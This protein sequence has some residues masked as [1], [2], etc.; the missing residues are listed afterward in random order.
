MS[1]PA[2]D[3]AS[4]LTLTPIDDPTT[5]DFNADP[6]RRD[7]PNLG[8]PRAKRYLNKYSILAVV[9]S[10]SCLA[11]TCFT[12]LPHFSIPWKLGVIRQFQIIGFLLSL[13]N[14]CFLTV[15]SKFFLLVEARFGHSYLQNYNAIL[16]NSFTLPSTNYIWRGVLVSVILMPISLSLVY[17]EFNSGTAQSRITNN[18]SSFYG[19]TGPAGL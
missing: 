15:A 17:K 9:G 13:M 2:Q 12:V 4:S 8:K 19:L 10:L 5:D 7:S 1:T 14:Q 3:K 16:R 18:T 11:I 6:V